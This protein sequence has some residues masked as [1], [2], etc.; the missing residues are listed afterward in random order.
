VGLFFFFFF[1]SAPLREIS[2]SS[3]RGGQSPTKQSMK[4][5]MKLDCRAA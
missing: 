4:L 3:L 5:A 2:S 1:F